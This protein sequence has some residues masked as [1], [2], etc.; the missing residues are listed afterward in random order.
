MKTQLV[1]KRFNRFWHWMQ[2]GLIFF[3]ALTGFEIHG[4]LSFFGFEHAVHYH[5]VA[6]A[7]FMVLIVFAIFWH[8]TT[9]EWKQ[10]LPT[11][12][13]LREQIA[14]YLDGIFHNA[15]HPT[16]KTVLS[17]LN[18]LQRLVYLALK[19]LVIPVM[20]MSGL[21]YMFYRYPQR[22]GIESFQIFSLETVALVHT[23]GAFILISFVIVHLY[24]ITTGRTLTS[25]LK[26]MVTGYED[27]DEEEAHAPAE[28]KIGKEVDNVEVPVE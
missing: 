10:Y 16:A 28:V 6:A 26:A 24:L 9:G 17:K 5:S 7:M 19:V 12:T 13:N 1:Y 25:N 2:A 3:L 15:P 27:L 8:F 22:Y 21:L 18:P 14:F 4:S 20:V 23:I 11:V